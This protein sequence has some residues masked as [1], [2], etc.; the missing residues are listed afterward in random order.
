M[1]KSVQV[2]LALVALEVAANFTK[3]PSLVA[4]WNYAKEQM[5]E[6][7]GLYCAYGRAISLVIAKTDMPLYLILAG[8]LDIKEEE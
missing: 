1:K 7:Y 3:N 8:D 2:G 6:N 5:A 4:L